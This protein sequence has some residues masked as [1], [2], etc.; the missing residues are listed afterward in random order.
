M[1]FLAEKSTAESSSAIPL[2][3]ASGGVSIALNFA[4]DD[5]EDATELSINQGIGNMALLVPEDRPNRNQSSSSSAAIQLQPITEPIFGDPSI[6]NVIIHSF[7]RFHWRLCS[8]TIP[9]LLEKK[10]TK[11]NQLQPDWCSHAF[12]NLNGCGQLAVVLCCYHANGPF[13]FVR[14]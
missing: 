13:S 4:S 2:V 12:W 8:R 5:E 3:P 14:V 6:G 1:N 9:T 11:W 7:S 10:T